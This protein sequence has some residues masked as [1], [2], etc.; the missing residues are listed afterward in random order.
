MKKLKALVLVAVL[1][2]SMLNSQ[3]AEARKIGGGTIVHAN[4]CVSTVEY[5]QALFGLITWEVETSYLC[6]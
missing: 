5:H 6:P 4:G 1:A 2:G 3:K